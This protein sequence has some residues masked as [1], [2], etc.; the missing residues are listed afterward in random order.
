MS[1]DFYKILGVERDASAS[2]IKTAYRKLAK[3]YHPDISKENN[4]EAKFKKVS[5]AYETLSDPQK[6]SQYDNF[7]SSGPGENSGFSGGYYQS[8]NDAGNSGFD[9]LGDI[10]SSFFGGNRKQSSRNEYAF[11]GDDKS[12]KIDISFKD[13]IFGVKKTIKYE[14]Q[15]ECNKCGGDGVKPGSKLINCTVCNGSGKI[16]QNIST[17]FGRMRNETTCKNCS[18]S[19]RI[20]EKKCT[21]CGGRG[22]ELKNEEIEI[23]IPA[24][25]NNGSIIRYRGKGDFGEKGGENGDLLL[26][27]SVS[28]SKKFER[29][30]FDIFSEK[31]IHIVEAT[32][33][34][35]INIETVH[36]NVKLKIPAGTQ[37]HTNFKIKK[38]GVKKEGDHFVKIIVNIPKKL[39]SEEKELYLKIAKLQ[40]KNINLEKGL[41]DKIF[42]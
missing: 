31:K 37:S 10:F 39:S 30:D 41:W 28:R 21:S 23:N 38:Y 20:P 42:G 13:A 24:G 36:G 5:E 35:N 29:D 34:A 6:K 15:K 7:G 22:N 27:V 26:H 12:F 40:G 17:P 3:K 8:H 9:D 33:G 18:G 16:V 25:V 11:H 4:A 32:L 14:R 1:E 19:G 2:Q